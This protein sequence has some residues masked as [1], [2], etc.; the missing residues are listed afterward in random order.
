M[1][2][3]TAP[4]TAAAAAAHQTELNRRN[5]TTGTRTHMASRTHV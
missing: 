1:M 2:N 3:I 5:T 4:T